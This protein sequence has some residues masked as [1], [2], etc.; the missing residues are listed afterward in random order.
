MTI[1]TTKPE[2]ERFWSKVNKDGPLPDPE[3]Y[4]NLKERCWEWTA[5]T[6][7]GY[8][9]FGVNVG[10]RKFRLE[11]SHRWS[12]RASKGEIPDSN[13]VLHHCDNRLCVNPDHLF[14]GTNNDNVWDKLQKGRGSR[15]ERMGMAKLNEF[16]VRIIRRLRE[17]RIPNRVM[18][19]IFGVTTATAQKAAARST[20]THV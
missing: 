7:D 17:R 1:R 5:G 6:T 20:W 3:L 14:I 12:W 19:Q 4:P 11:L 13:Q 18:A 9:R 8:G 16:Q 15:G 10:S 2:D